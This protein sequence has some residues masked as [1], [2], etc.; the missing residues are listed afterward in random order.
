MPSV[1]SQKPRGKFKAGDDLRRRLL[2]TANRLFRES[3][4]ENVSVRSI[5]QEVGC[6]QMAMYRHFPDKESLVRH[7]C[8]AI[9]KQFTAGLSTKFD[10]LPDPKE[11][12]RRALCDFVRLAAANPHHYRFTFLARISDQKTE[13]ARTATAEPVIAYIRHTLGLA[14]PPGSSDE[15][16]EERL[17]QILAVT[18][19]LIVMLIT[20]PRAYRITREGALAHLDSALAILL[21]AHPSH[22]GTA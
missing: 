1:T 14:L 2:E 9:Y 6:S 22:G 18:H 5:A 13:S 12:V 7:L 16:V 21:E 4:Y 11:R 17:H 15:L 20:Y 10:H 19:G 8:N 3:G